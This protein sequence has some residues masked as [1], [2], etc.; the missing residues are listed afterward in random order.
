MSC[1]RVLTW[2]VLHRV[3]AVNWK[4]APV[5]SFPDE[6]TR[7]ERIAAFIAGQLASGIE[8]VCLQEVS[9]DQQACLAALLAGRA[10]FFTHRYPRIPEFRDN[11]AA[12]QSPLAD[13]SEFLVMIVAEEIGRSAH[14]RSAATFANDSGKGYLAVDLAGGIL[15]IDT[16]VT[17]GE[18]GLDQLALLSRTATGP[19]F[20]AGDFNAEAAAV[21]AR[22]DRTSP[23]PTFTLSD[24]SGQRHTRIAT[25]EKQS[26]TIDHIVVQKGSIVAATVLDGE[27][28]SDH[29]PVTATLHFPS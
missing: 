17:W 11:T 6:R 16:H 7:I 4:E 29:N 18:R 28:L 14:L 12:A 25:A 26:H 5:A 21:A 2:N 23:A 19:V 27:G 15:A 22:L 1:L 8:V 24:L 13:P 10:V 3:H 20:L 9:G